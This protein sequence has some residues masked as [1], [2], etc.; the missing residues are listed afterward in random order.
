MV[1]KTVGV[2]KSQRLAAR[3]SAVRAAFRDAGPVS[4]W[5]GG[6]TKK[7][8]FDSRM[9]HRPRIHGP[10][11][12]SVSV[13]RELTG[14]LQLYPIDRAAYPNEAVLG[15][16]D[17]VLP[18][19]RQWLNRQLSKKETGVL[20]CEELIIEWREGKHKIHELRFL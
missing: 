18:R 5:M 14:T 8:A 10:V 4:I 20:G 6:L 12:A 7:L 1:L 9:F 19:M 17:E 3:R 11:V 2:P 16:E 15:F 13:S